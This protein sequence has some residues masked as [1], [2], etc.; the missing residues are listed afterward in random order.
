MSCL[1]DV[2]ESSLERILFHQVLEEIHGCLEPGL[3]VA[4]VELENSA[5][6]GLGNLADGD[7]VLPLEEGFFQLAV[8][9]FF[10]QVLGA[11]Q[12]RR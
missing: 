7:V 2:V 10:E 8:L 9:H 6:G 11:Q 3:A 4:M 5:E 12:R 1:K